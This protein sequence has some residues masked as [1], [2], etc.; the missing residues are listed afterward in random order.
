MKSVPAT[1]AVNLQG[2][3]VLL[4]E[5]L[6]GRPQPQHRFGGTNER[7]GAVARH[8]GAVQQP[9]TGKLRP[10]SLDLEHQRADMRRHTEHL[11]VPFTQT[12]AGIERCL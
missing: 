9:G 8:P 11:K 10:R 1:R 4:G 3:S 7:C 5:R 6:D 12:T 2:V